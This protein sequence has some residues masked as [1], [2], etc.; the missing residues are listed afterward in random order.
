MDSQGSKVPKLGI[1]DFRVVVLRIRYRRCTR[2]MRMRENG[3]G[4]D[5]V[6]QRERGRCTRDRIDLEMGSQDVVS[7]KLEWDVIV[8]GRGSVAL[9]CAKSGSNPRKGFKSRARAD[10]GRMGISE[11]G[12]AR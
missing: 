10:Q 3:D 1:R 7:T 11:D 5:Q 8:V 6:A 2:S 9:T 12:E 4:A